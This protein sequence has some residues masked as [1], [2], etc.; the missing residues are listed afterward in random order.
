MP[1]VVVIGGGFGGLAAVRA[2]RRAPVAITLIDRTNHHVFQPLLYQV[3]T[4]GL[5]PADIAAPIR[6]IVSQQKNVQV[7]MGEVIGIDVAAR[8]VLMINRVETYDM[9]VLA[10]G[11]SHSYFGKPEWERFAPGLKTITDATRLRR[12]ILLAFEAAENES[13]PSVRQ[14]LLTFVLVGAGPTGVEMAGAIAE[15]AH[16]ALAADFRAINPHQTRIVLLEA[17]PRILNSFDERLAARAHN[18]L[19]RMGVDVRCGFPVEAI[20]EA[21]VMVDGQRIASRTVI[22]TAGV[23]ASSLTHSLGVSLDRAGRVLVQPDLSIDG[24]PEVFVIGDASAVV[25]A[26]KPLPGV[27]PVAMQQGCY[28]GTVIARRV[29]GRVAPPP[30]HYVDKGNMATVGRS[31]AIMDLRGLR[32]SGFIA[33]SLWLWIHIFFLIGFRNRLLV[34]LQWA[35]AYITFDRGARLITGE[36]KSH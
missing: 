10:P 13:D 5:S 9:L 17:A 3:A 23:K 36:T 8:R 33:W 22:W 26:G 19:T 25:Q 32:L 29:A 30:F 35:W 24:H 28:V 34:M 16:R 6:N 20:D 18:A 27:A 12:D 11:A 31:F 4:A 15:L 14:A 1:Q 7:R 2:L 21:G